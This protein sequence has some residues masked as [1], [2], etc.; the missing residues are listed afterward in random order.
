VHKKVK[1]SAS[2]F[3]AC[4]V[5]FCFVPTDFVSMQRFNS[6]QFCWRRPVKLSHLHT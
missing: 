2:Y 1:N 6:R 3:R 5:T 4:F